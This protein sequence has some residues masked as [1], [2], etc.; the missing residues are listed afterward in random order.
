[1]WTSDLSGA[2]G[3][4]DVDPVSRST[5]VLFRVRFILAPNNARE[6]P[7][8]F[9]I[10][11][12]LRKILRHSEM[13]ISLKDIASREDELEFI[14]I[15]ANRG[16]FIDLALSLPVTSFITGFEPIPTLNSALQKKYQRK[17]NVTIRSEAISSK[18]E[19]RSFNINISRPELS[20]FEKLTPS[21]QESYK[22]SNIEMLQVESITLDSFLKNRP[23]IPFFLKVD[24]Q[25]HDYDI[26][27]SL[28][29]GAVSRIKYILCEVPINPIYENSCSWFDYFSL[30]Y[31]LGFEPLAFQRVAVNKFGHLIETDVLLR[32]RNL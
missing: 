19:V 4:L 26:L 12:K 6:D 5:S 23:M 21:G 3:I 1:M 31:S 14:D 11:R 22:A 32:N 20:S 25:G 13:Q 17:P 15:G 7:G 27:N 30:I 29:W 9:S 16:D 18:D 24:A 28:S 8:V 2:D 10:K